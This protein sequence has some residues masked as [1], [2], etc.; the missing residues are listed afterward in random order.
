MGVT[1][2]YAIKQ[3]ELLR[4]SARW[5]ALARASTK[6][7]L[8]AEHQFLSVQ[9]PASATTCH[10]CGKQLA[11][12]RLASYLTM[13][14]RNKCFECRACFFVCHKACMPLKVDHNCPHAT[15]AMCLEYVDLAAE[16][17]TSMRA[18][19]SSPSLAMFASLRRG[20]RRELSASELALAEPAAAAGRRAPKLASKSTS[21]DA[22]GGNSGQ[23][24]RANAASAV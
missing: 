4:K 24:R 12:S 11:S 7:H 18:A 3:P 8:F 19:S 10:A 23:P 6:I 14:S 5:S 2:Y 21:V 9:Q 22:H 13:M 1:H 17:G 20:A 15:G 16:L